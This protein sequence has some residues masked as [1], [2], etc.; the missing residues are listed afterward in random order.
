MMEA[1]ESVEA[2]QEETRPRGCKGSQKRPGRKVGSE[3][4]E[5]FSFQ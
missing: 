5:E 1:V 2:D 4:M 3:R